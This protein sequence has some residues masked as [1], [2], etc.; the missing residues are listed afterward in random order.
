MSLFKKIILSLLYIGLSSSFVYA[1]PSASLTLDPENPSPKSSVSIRLESYSFDVNTATI[2]WTVNGSV[3][4]KG[5]GERTLVL[6]TGSVG[7]SSDVSVLA[8]T[9]DGSSIQQTITITPSSVLLLY[10]TPGSYVPLLYEGR[11]LPSTGALV[12]VTAL[13]QISDNGIMLPPSS[14]SFVWSVNDSVFKGASGLGKQSA[15]IRLDYLKTKNDIK[16]VARS[17]LGNTGSK[18]ITVYTH[19]VM[20]MLYLYDQ[21]LGTVFTSLI[22]N[23]F[24]TVQDFTVILEPFYLAKKG[25]KDPSYNWFIDG[26]PTTPLDGRILSLH[27][28]ENSYGSKKLN[29]LINGPDKRLQK[30]EIGTEFIFDTRK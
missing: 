17:P 8:E 4:L 9:A 22:G 14:L 28:K 25:P 29:I 5:M 24:E 12:K 20:P 6:K 7:E 15:S 27:P 19:P 18:T 10:E 30:A 23:R 11:S 3:V 2:T 21:I 16:V 26:L 13:P 1:D